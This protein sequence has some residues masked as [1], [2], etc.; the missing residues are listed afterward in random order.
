MKS[1]SKVK[2]SADLQSVVSPIRN[3]QGARKSQRARH[4]RRHAGSNP[5]IQQIANLRYSFLPRR[6]RAVG[7]TLFPLLVLLVSFS[8]GAGAQTSASDYAVVEGIFA[9]HCLDCHAAQD[10]EGKLVLESFASLLRGGETGPALI[11]GKSDESL[12]VQM[13]EGRLEKNGK[14]KVMP[15]GKR[16]KLETKEIAALKA[17]IDAGAPPPSEPAR[18]AV[19]ELVTPKISP[20]VPPRRAIQAV[21][22]DPGSKLIAVARYAEVELR[23][24]EN[25]ALVRTLSGHHGNV[26]AI[27][28]AADGKQLAAAAGEPGLSG[29]ARLWNVADGTLIRTFAGHKD[30]L[31]AIAISP[32]GKTLATGSY[33]HKIKLWNL[34]T[35][36]ERRTLSAHNGAVFDL[37]FRP[38]GKI[39]ASASGDRTVK[40]WE[41]ESG[42]RVETLSQ[43]LKELYAVSFSPDG[44]RL[45]A[46]G[47][48]NRIRV[49]E[50]SDSAAETSNPILYAKFAHEGAIL[51]LVYSSDGKTLLSSAEDGTVKLWEAASITEKLLL[52]PQP[53]L[54][55]ALAFANEGKSVVVG[56]L[57]GTLEIYDAASGQ[58]VPLPAPEIARIEPRGM[59]RGTTLQLKLTGKNLMGLTNVTASHPKLMAELLSR[60]SERADEAT[61][62]LTAAPDLPRGPYEVSVMGAGGAGKIKLHVDDLPQIFGSS[63]SN[64][65]ASRAAS[66]LPASFWGTLKTPGDEDSFPFQAQAGQ[67]ILF[68]LAA[69]SLGSKMAT[70]SLTL[71]DA[72]GA[73]LASNNGFDGDEPFL[74]YRIPKDGAYAIRVADQML[75]A[76]SDH[77]YRLS[78][79]ALP[80]VTAVFPLAVT[81][82]REA[83]V[84]L[85]GYNLPAAATATVRCGA[86]GEIDVPIDANQFRSRRAFKLLVTEGAE[87]TESEPNDS[88]ER[89]NRISAPGAVSGRIWA[90]HGAGDADVY[91]FEAKAGQ[92]LSSRRWLRSGV[93]RRTPGLKCWTPMDSR[94]SVCCSKRSATPPSP[95]VAS[96]PTRPIAGS[97]TGR[98]W[99]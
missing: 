59:Q 69:K 46:G 94:C 44:K 98:K 87:L 9:K 32:D 23:S 28:F 86:A 20:L 18:I 76:S 38:D 56:R 22:Y 50:I 16:K 64:A 88:P 8:P 30:A 29:E 42:K 66:R 62:R 5:A 61:I 45:V 37:S 34:E 4:P 6:L 53:D 54:A 70:P 90:E 73:V 99:S 67:M 93:G 58:R 75:G 72:T 14:R 27:A 71:T 24:A 65:A 68:D 49:W 80:Y 78:A 97:R 35:G 36:D 19:R 84:Q 81:T 91:R 40:L 12:L 39:L 43:S 47:V 79:G 33:D 63:R 3:R 41:V 60:A 2:S 48:D 55:P 25:R 51:N 92:A 26:N 7:L 77:F 95:S 15:P 31:Y 85:I 11:A 1:K 74:A 21:A 17:W 96:V 83:E 89:A 82:N 57:D 10:P 52:E 13:V